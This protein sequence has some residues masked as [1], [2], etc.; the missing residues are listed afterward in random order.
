MAPTQRQ[1]VQDLDS[2]GRKEEVPVSE[3][4]VQP[5]SLDII[6]DLEYGV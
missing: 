6:Y 2:T 4:R 3:T 1:V 5:P